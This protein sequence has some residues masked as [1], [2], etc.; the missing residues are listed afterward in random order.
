V[1]LDAYVAEHADEWARLDTLAGRRRLD[2]AESDELIT[3]YQRAATHLSV[4]QSRSPDPA[5]VGRL[6]RLVSRG[7]AAVTGS[8][9]PAWRDVARFFTVSFPVAVY[10]AWRWWCG[11]ATASSLV[12]FGLMAYVAAHPA[13]QTRL[14]PPDE[15]RQLVEHDFADYYSAHP[16]QNFAAQVWTN[17]ALLTAVC[18]VSGILVVPVLYLLVTNMA[19]V[20]IVG[21]IMIGQGRG[22][23][24]WGLVTPHGLLEIMCVFVGAGVGLRLGWAWIAPGRRRTRTQAL[25][26]EG[27]AG[28]VVAL[29]LAGVLAV[30]G[31]IEAF[32]TPSPLP[33]WG[34]VGIGVAA[35]VGFHL[36]VVLLGRRAARAGETGDLERGLREDLAPL[37]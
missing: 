36:Y 29:G 27:R 11:V 3:L 17:N 14:L 22:D 15:I 12:A 37:A 24:F 30:T 1:D 19:S 35:F 5:L 28:V 9:A 33:T 25:A 32:V 13:V 6:S 31:V 8:S 20:G 2:G 10:R 7:R 16:A 34:R 23:V 4:V 26:E 18:L 21:G